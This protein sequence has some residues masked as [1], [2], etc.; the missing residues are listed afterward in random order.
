M[1]RLKSGITL[2]QA[3]AQMSVLAGQLAEANPEA[4]EAAM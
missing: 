4:T 3:Q 1:G 2:E